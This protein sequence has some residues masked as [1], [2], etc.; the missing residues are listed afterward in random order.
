MS[1]LFALLL[2]VNPTEPPAAYYNDAGEVV[3]SNVDTAREIAQELNE[4]LII[5]A[6]AFKDMLPRVKAGTADLAIADITITEARKKDVN[7]SRPYQMGGGLFLHPANV[8]APKMSQIANA[9]V[10]V[11]I[12]TMGDVY[13][14]RHGC[15]P[16]RYPTIKEAMAGLES[17]EVDMIYFD[18]GPMIEYANESNGRYVVTP[19][20]TRE[21]YGIAITKGRPDVLAV[22]NKVLD[23]KLGAK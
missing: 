22:A 13:L 2:L 8:P 18:I 12:D 23:R 20:V 4:P 16:I 6:S 17:G 11:G 21:F 3:G 10:G 7:F 1:V 15:D 19:L 14:S 5:E 9:R